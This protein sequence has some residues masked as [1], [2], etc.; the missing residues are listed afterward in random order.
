MNYFRQLWY[1]MRH[2]KMMTWVAISGTAVSIF[3]VMVM[4]MVNSLKTVEVAP[5][6]NRQRI[7]AGMT[8]TIKSTNP[9]DNWMTRGNM[10]YPLA[11]RLYGDLKGVELVSY[12]G[13]SAY[14]R[15][16]MI[17]DKV[18][19]NVSTKMV[20]GKF[21]KMFDFNFLEGEPFTEDDCLGNTNK[22]VL[23]RSLAHR[24]FSTQE[25]VGREINLGRDKYVISGVVEDVNPILQNIWADV[26]TP[27]VSSMREDDISRYN[28]CGYFMALM[29]YEKKTDPESV[30][31]QVKSRYATLNA[32]WAKEGAE[33]VYNGVPYDAEQLGMTDV[34]YVEPD[35]KKEHRTQY[36]I[37]ALLL[38]LPAI[39]LS[40]MMRGR[41]RHRVSEIGVRRAYG[42][43]RRDI[44]RQ[45]IGE[46][47]VVTVVGGLI[48]LG[49]SYLFMLTLSSEFFMFV[50]G[51][52]I[53]SL[54]AMMAIPSFGMLF[55]WSTFFISVG[56]CLVLNLLTATV[57]AWRASMM[58]PAVAISKSRT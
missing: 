41:L 4:F 3:L 9:E 34:G 58:E 6:I 53:S 55:T 1:D 40:S 36:V 49:L 44:I 24:L 52:R 28:A 48:G 38:L 25:V 35:V 13:Q 15:D 22:I 42:A 31:A 20:D 5:D 8:V 57:P 45:L 14:P 16:V 33:L 27:V 19:V 12:C 54:E 26:Y 32:E 18:P 51:N 39:N 7:Y 37:Y 47:L 56:A 46:N 23:T 17:K 2:Q 43:K 11:Q 10:N 50:D 30:K 29:L 21:W